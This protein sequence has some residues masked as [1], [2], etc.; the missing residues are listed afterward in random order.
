MVIGRDGRRTE[1]QPVG[2]RFEAALL[3][4][5]RLHATQTR[6]ATA[7][8]YIAHLLG[9]A[10]LVLEAGGDEDQ[11]IAALFHD[12]VEDQGGDDTWSGIHEFFGD[13]VGEIISACTD[14]PD[15]VNHTRENSLERKRW[16]LVHLS[17]EVQEE[18]LIV[19]LAD[20]LHNA[21]GIV[22]DLRTLGED[23]WS[24]FNVGKD[25]QLWYY[26]RLAVI[27]ERRITASPLRPLVDEFSRTVA[28]M[29][30]LAR[31]PTSPRSG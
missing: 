26:R 15:V 24:R 8:P 12:A 16:Y 5:F 17:N 18:A 13:R 20:K 27:F 30:R 6:K 14:Q 7:T 11:A 21:R 2:F 9:V 29:E 1:E 19:V 22:M 28:E 23:L 10:A 3:Y 25:D 4:A 31:T